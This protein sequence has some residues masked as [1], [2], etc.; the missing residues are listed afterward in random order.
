MKRP[1]CLTDHD[2]LFTLTATGELGRIDYAPEDLRIRR[3]TSAVLW[4]FR[5]RPNGWNF[6]FVD[7]DEVE[8]A[9]PWPTTEDR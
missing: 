3:R 4:L 6:V 5:P 7:E 9:P 8:P 2:R 1:F